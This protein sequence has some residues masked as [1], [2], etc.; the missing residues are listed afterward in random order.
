MIIS[1][2][3]L[4]CIPNEEYT[5]RS[6]IAPNAW[7]GVIGGGQLAKM[8]SISAQKLGYR[9][10]LWDPDPK[11][12]AHAVCNHHV[13][14]KFEDHNAYFEFK[15]CS[16][17]TVEFE[18]LPLCLLENLSQFSR[19]TPSAYAISITQDR[20]REKNF[21][22]SI[23]VRVVPYFE[24]VDGYYFQDH[25]TQV[26]L[27]E[28]NIIKFLPGILKTA[29]M[30][31]DG[32]GQ[33]K[34]SDVLSLKRSTENHSCKFV[35]EKYISLAC[36]FSIILCRDL[37][38]KIVSYPIQK[39]R[40]QNGILLLTT[41]PAIDIPDN[42]KNV[43]DA[44]SR[45]IAINL[46][47]VGVLCIEFFLDTDGI[48]FVNELA[49][50]PHNSGHYTIEACETSQFE[51][52]VRIMAGLPL[53]STLQHSF[54]AMINLLGDLWIGSSSN[55]NNNIL[56]SSEKKCYGVLDWHSLLSIENAHLHLYGKSTIRK[57]RKMG[58]VTLTAKKYSM[59]R[60]KIQEVESVL[61][62]SKNSLKI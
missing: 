19:V 40:H 46:N 58:H 29:T 24:I 5:D 25:K 41:V 50:R 16:A 11:A 3:I 31:Y 10:M 42:I 26:L 36:E 59:L 1:P 62:F 4:S 55:N 9:V 60:Y 39:N 61:G 43:A 28:K 6:M 52:Q 17:I 56:F 14:A 32:K 37:F 35:L 34:I 51:Q 7:L 22:K 15:K 12:P 8:F 53:G 13:I 33:E 21:L 47:Y 23:D 54:S 57:G 20:L 45:H 49:P 44:I 27:D 2:S 38:G 30:G 48:L 18:N